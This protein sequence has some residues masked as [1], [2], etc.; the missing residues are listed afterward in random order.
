[1][2]RR[3]SDL[4]EVAALADALTTSDQ[5]GT[6]VLADA[7]IVEDRLHLLFRDYRSERGAAVEQIA[8]AERFGARRKP[9]HHFVVNAFL[10]QHTRP[11]R[12]HLPRVE[13]DAGSSGLRCSF[14]VSIIE[15]PVRGLGADLERDTFE[16]AGGALH[17]ATAD[18]GRARERHLV[19][20]AMIDQRIADDTAGSGDDIEHARRQ[21]G[22]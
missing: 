21:A 4:D 5:R 2:T 8:H 10:H 22:F 20:I 17:D 13:E 14:E 19:D 1:P 11:G 6:L 18:A 16:I 15:D 12:A 3:S 7:D 9:L